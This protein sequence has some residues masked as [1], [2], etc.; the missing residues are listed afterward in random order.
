MSVDNNL[1]IEIRPV[2][3]TKG[4]KQFSENLEYFSQPKTIPP[5]VD[6]DT[7]RYATGLTE[8]D[9][10]YLEDEGFPYN[11]KDDR[12]VPRQAHEFWESPL[13]KAE[14][15][16]SPTFLYPGKNPIDFIKWKYLSVSAYV[17]SSAEQMKEGSKPEAT[18]YIYNEEKE[19]E[20]KASE[21][22]KK[23]QLISKVSKLSLE[24]KKQLILIILNEV[25]DNKPASYITVKMEEIVSDTSKKENKKELLEALLED[26]KEDVALLADVKTAISKGVLTRNKKG[27]FYF[28]NNLGLFEKDVVKFLKDSENS[29]ILINIKSKIE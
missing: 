11:F 3:N 1:K 5:L 23:D 27:I 25:V 4:I 7:R 20:L 6:P 26:S 13:V 12:F 2:P 14:L 17:Y 18:H 24:R 19:N 15:P 21:I 29:E 10:K 22:E 16:N 9:I 8:E 28:E